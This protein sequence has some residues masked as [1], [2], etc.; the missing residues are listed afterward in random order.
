MKSTDSILKVLDYTKSNKKW[1]DDKELIAG[2]HSVRIDGDVYKGQRDP[3]K[4]LAKVGYEF[5]G[6]RVLDVGCS[7]GGLL[8]ALSDQLSFGVGVD[9]NSKCINAA[10]ALK[11]V[12]HIDNIH[13]YTF[14]L[15]TRKPGST[16]L[17]F[18]ADCLR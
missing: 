4:R 13:F 3:E 7:N 14:D 16:E 10:N 11:A 12:N 5:K 17:D 1:F 15:G 2:Y 9:F 18:D 6:K 8:H